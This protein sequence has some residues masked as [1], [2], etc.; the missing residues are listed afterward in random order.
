M[1]YKN[2]RELHL[3]GEKQQVSRLR[4]RRNSVPLALM[5]AL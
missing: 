3:P 1:G 4:D 2:S 5:P